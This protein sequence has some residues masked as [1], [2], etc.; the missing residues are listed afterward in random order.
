MN[1]IFRTLERVYQQPDVNFVLTNCVPRR[2]L[3]LMMSRISRIEQPWIKSFCIAVWRTFCDVDLSDARKSAFNS[4]HDCFIRELR[5][6]ARPVDPRPDVVT[7]PCDAIVGQCGALRSGVALQAKGRSYWLAELLED[8]DLAAEF[9]GGNYATLR[10]TAGMY[11]R[12]HAPHDC[13]LTRAT[14]IGGDAWNVNPPALQRVPRLYCRNER[15]VVR[16]KLDCG[17]SMLLVPVAAIL[18]AGIRLHSIPD[19]LNLR[20]RGRRDFTCDT[21]HLKVQELGWFEHGSTIIAITPA[22]LPIMNGI[23]PGHAIRMGEGLFCFT[24]APRTQA[25]CQL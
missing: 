8:T 4:L 18:V 2:T 5:D 9:A 23:A 1:P 10:L 19:L 14:Y 20:H 25:K 12:F 24:D 17:A 15:A 3:T 13:T 16:L 11:H 7:S 6:G 22:N 21:H